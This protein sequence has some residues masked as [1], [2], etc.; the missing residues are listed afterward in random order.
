M[1]LSGQILL[2]GDVIRYRWPQRRSVGSW[3]VAVGDVRIIGEATTPDGPADDY[4][5]CF[6]IGP[7]MWFEASFYAEGRDA[8][9]RA[10]GERLGS[11]LE[12]GLCNST[13]FASRVLWPSS[14]TGEP[15]FRYEIIPPKGI[16]GRVLSSMFGPLQN[17]QMYTERV[18]AALTNGER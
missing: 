14:L 1:T 17:R 10:L 18:T 16:V 6:A 3:E 5:L 9:L 15:M 11:P 12:L 8:F 2:E 7:E 4:F 13:D